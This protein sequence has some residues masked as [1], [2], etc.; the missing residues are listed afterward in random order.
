MPSCRSTDYRF[1]VLQ[2]VDLDGSLRDFTDLEESRAEV[3]RKDIELGQALQDR[4]SSVTQVTSLQEELVKAKEER[5]TFSESVATL[6]SEYSC[7][8][9]SV[10]YFTLTL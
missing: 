5:N 7:C 10:I 8:G 4:E 3:G 9:I 6:L 2:S 1:I